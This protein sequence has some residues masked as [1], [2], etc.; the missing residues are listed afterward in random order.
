MT[1]ASKLRVAAAQIPIHADMDRNL[2]QIM[3][4][5]RGCAAL[6]A[7]L[8]VFPETALTGYAPAIGSGRDSAQWSE[9]VS[10]LERIRALAG[11]LGLWTV[12]GTDAWEEGAWYN[13]LY[14]YSAQGVQVT[15]YDKMHLMDTDTHYYRSGKCPTLFEIRGIR[16]GL[17]ICY[18]VRFPEGYRTL[19]RQGTQVVVQGFYG[20]GGNT[21]KVPVLAAH[22]RSRAAENG[23]FMVAANVSG[24]LQ[25][26]TSQIIDP[27]GLVL[28][29]AN[30]DHDELIVAD[31][32]L[33]RI[34]ESE[35]RRNYFERHAHVEPA[36]A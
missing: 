24:P 19:L 34:A 32:D 11:A 12:V 28:A 21:W 23:C 27:L 26:V 33:D 22:L 3:R 35:I 9:I 1:D 15:T 10:R 5:M 31:L 36:G 20:A 4:A 25:I 29:E 6:G 17:Q 18:D 8:A 7:E 2:E 14:V 13:R 16:V 30:Q